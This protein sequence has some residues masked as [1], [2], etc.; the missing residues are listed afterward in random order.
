MNDFDKLM[1]GQL[2]YLFLAVGLGG[3]PPPVRDLDLTGVE[4][5]DPEVS[6]SVSLSITT[7]ATWTRPNSVSRCTLRPSILSSFFLLLSAVIREGF[8]KINI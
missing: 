4:S 2:P 3:F 5:R 7:L 6:S 1:L 8:R